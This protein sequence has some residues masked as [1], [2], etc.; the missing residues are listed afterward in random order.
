MA[1]VSGLG[2]L[3]EQVGPPAFL[4]VGVAELLPPFEVCPPPLFSLLLSAWTGGLA[5]WAAGA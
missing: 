2:A 1:W 3:R 4:C 5:R